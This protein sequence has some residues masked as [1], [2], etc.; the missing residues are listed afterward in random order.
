MFYQIKFGKSYR[1]NLRIKRTCEKSQSYETNHSKPHVGRRRFY[2]QLNKFFDAVDK[3]TETTQLPLEKTI[4]IGDKLR[5]RRNQEEQNEG[6]TEK[7]LR[8]ITALNRIK[9]GDVLW[10]YTIK[11]LTAEQ[12]ICG[13]QFIITA[14]YTSKSITDF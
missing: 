13:R 7:N 3:L 8:E 10:A 6:F 9:L 5:F 4:S 1:R 2:R 12:K 14:P 11:T